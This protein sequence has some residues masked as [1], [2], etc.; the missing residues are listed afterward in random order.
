MNYY[1]KLQQSG[2]LSKANEELEEARI[3]IDYQI[4][5]CF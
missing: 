2:F 1:D 5:Q 3:V 4:D